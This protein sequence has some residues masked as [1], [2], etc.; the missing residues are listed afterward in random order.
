MSPTTPQAVLQ[1]CSPILLRIIQEKQA[2]RIMAAGSAIDV[3][4]LR[5]RA[6][7]ILGAPNG[8]GQTEGRSQPSSNSVTTPP[9]PAPIAWTD[10]AQHAIRNALVTATTG[11]PTFLDVPRCLL[12][13][14]PL[15]FLHSLWTELLRSA[16]MNGLPPSQRLAVF[17]LTVPRVRLSP[18]MTRGMTLLPIFLQSTLPKIISST[19]IQSSRD[20]PTELLV[21]IISSSLTASFYLVGDPI[22]GQTVDS[23][24]AIGPLARG[25]AK[26]LQAQQFT[27]MTS[28]T[29]LQRLSAMPIFC[30]HF[31]TFAQ[32]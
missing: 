13:S 5:Q 19:D 27:S 31:P 8:P 24:N 7:A 1:I 26:G 22:D 9:V 12:T 10:L 25:V 3:V 23:T 14:T 16:M 32:T 15:H 30:T 18:D 6:L 11:R 17:V 20:L 2:Q 29:I 4:A 28:R 21:G